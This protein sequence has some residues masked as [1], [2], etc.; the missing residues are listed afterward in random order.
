MK[1]Y[2]IERTRLGTV[3]ATVN[4][5]PLPR[6]EYHSRSGFNFGNASKESQDL[7]LSILADYYE[8]YPTPEQLH[9]GSC[10]CWPMHQKFTWQI[11]ATQTDSNAFTITEEDIQIW[12]IEQTK[13]QQL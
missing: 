12:L 10:Y 9:R 5:H 6:V 4:D 13:K 7:A 11:I 2:R 1:V 8:E 3:H